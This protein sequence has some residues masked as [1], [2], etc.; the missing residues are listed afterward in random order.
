MK[1]KLL[2]NTI[3]LIL[4]FAPLIAQKADYSTI[5]NFPEYSNEKLNISFTDDIEWKNKSNIPHFKPYFFASANGWRHVL[6]GAY[7]EHGVTIRKKDSV[8]F[9]TSIMRTALTS[10]YK[11]ESSGLIEAKEI[12]LKQA[13]WLKDNFHTVDNN[14]GF[15]VFTNPSEAYELDPGWVS[16]MSQGMGVGVCLMAFNLTGDRE[17]LKIVDLALKGFYVPVENGGF[18]REFNNGL[19]FEEYPTKIPS[20]TLNGFLFSIAGLYNFYENTGSDRAK[21]LFENAAHTLSNNL[22]GYLGNFTS[23]Y[24]HKNIFQYAK[25]SYHLIHINQLAWL[26]TVTGN[27]KFYDYSKKFLE[28]HMNNLYF[29]PE[30]NFKK[31]TNISSNNCINCE[32]YGADNLFDDKWSWGKFW[33]SYKSPELLITLDKEKVIKSLILYGVNIKSVLFGISIYDK[34][35]NLLQRIDATSSLGNIDYKE[36]GGNETFIR[37]IKLSNPVETSYLKLKFSGTDRKNVLGLRELQLE[38]SMDSEMEEILNWI[39]AKK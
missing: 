38:V 35:D 4:G 33:S 12:F 32:E 18:N 37:K 13:L 26:Y 15:W 16:A 21:A 17:F 29:D 2:L 19:W 20:Y 31:I 34:N 10:Y 6:N 7:D 3:F 36:T 5:H 1:V 28:L 9:P 39:N 14:Y 23:Y 27:V 25:D 22:E 30:L 8:Y 24:S 11:Y